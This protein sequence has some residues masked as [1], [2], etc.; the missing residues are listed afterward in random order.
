MKKSEALFVLIKSMSSSEKRYFRLF[1]TRESSGANYLSLF[2]AMDAQQEYDERQLKNTLKGKTFVRQL[3]VTKNYLH[4]LILKSLRN[5]HADL[6]RDAALKNRL[7]NV[8]ILYHKELYEHAESELRKAREQAEKYELQTGLV[9]VYVWERRLEQALRPHN[10][11]GMEQLLLRHKEALLVLDNKHAYWDLAVQHSK[12]LGREKSESKQ[13]SELLQSPEHALSLE[14]KVLYFN[15]TYLQYLGNNEV[16]RAEGQLYA[17]ID[18][19]ERFDDR[20]REDPGLYV[21]SIN[22]LVSF[23]VFQKKYAA[24]SALIAKAKSVYEQW[25]LTAANR[26]LLKQIMRTYN[27]EMEMYRERGNVEEPI[28]FITKTE[29]FVQENRHKIPREYLVSFWFQFASIYF[30]RQEY[31][32]ALIWLNLLL[33]ARFKTERIDLQ[34]QARMLNLMV[35]LEQQN[36]FVLRYFVD[37]TK[38]YMK[39]VKNGQPFEEIL[40]RFFVQ[41]GKMPLYDYKAAYQELY[42]KLFPE[43]A[44]A[45][46]SEDALN[47][48]DYK[49]W[50]QQKL[51][52]KARS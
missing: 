4:K 33:N 16:D 41:I 2:D 44:E 39:K 46:V 20:I 7:Q 30:M 49:G 35:H 42:N 23:L 13:P 50:L 25:S 17:L 14:A 6:T 36:L 10:Y 40:L 43:N 28:A 12:T 8:E 29:A 15:T 18:L 38:R 9:E 27:I 3:H 5:F 19:L 1:C 11:V 48:I 22:N 32:K 21:S 52:Q 26:T 31:K 51:N 37:S 47:Y 45:L 24:A 34:V